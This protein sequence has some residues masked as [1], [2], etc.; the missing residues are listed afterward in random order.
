MQQRK[1]DHQGARRLLG[2]QTG[3]KAHPEDGARLLACPWVR[4]PAPDV[5]LTTRSG[6]ASGLRGKRVRVEVLE[7]VAT[8][9][10]PLSVG[11]LVEA[12][13]WSQRAFRSKG[14]RV[15][16]LRCQVAL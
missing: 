1:L 8:A 13:L 7:A 15:V 2:Q 3:I 10:E 12:D 16:A 14:V 4:M 6:T 5:Y 9:P 11:S